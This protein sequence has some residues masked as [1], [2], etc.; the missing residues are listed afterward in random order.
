MLKDPKWCTLYK[1]VGSTELP[2]EVLE[3]SLG[4]K[5]PPPKGDLRMAFRH[6]S[7][8]DYAVTQ[9]EVAAGGEFLVMGNKKDQSKYHYI[10]LASKL[11]L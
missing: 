7:V 10:P 2:D 4:T 5:R 11:N 6:E 8:R 3:N 9:Q 1:E